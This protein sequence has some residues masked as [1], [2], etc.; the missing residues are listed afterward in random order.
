MPYV[1]LAMG[2]PA[3]KKP[4]TRQVRNWIA[5]HAIM[6]TGAGTHGDKKKRN[7]RE[8]CRGKVKSW[9]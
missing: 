5:V 4:A 6:R 9:E 2:K 7:A 3:K 1:A 8:A